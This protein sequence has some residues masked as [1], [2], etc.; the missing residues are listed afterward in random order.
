MCI[1]VSHN[2]PMQRAYAALASFDATI[3]R[4]PSGSR[5]VAIRSPH[6]WSAGSWMTRPG[7]SQPGQRGVAVLRIDPQ[8]DPIVR[9][10]PGLILK[11]NAQVGGAERH[12]YIAG[13]PSR[14]NWYVTV[15][16]SRSR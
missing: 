12:C 7:S 16:P 6:G 14:G 5:T 15:A 4:L 2:N 11:A 9:R 10:H 3:I 8:R 1:D 13:S